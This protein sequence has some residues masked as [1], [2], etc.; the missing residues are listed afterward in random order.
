M[1]DVKIFKTNQLF[2]NYLK[3]LRF[4]N[5]VFKGLS[6]ESDNGECGFEG[7]W[8]S[9]G[10]VDNLLGPP[11]PKRGGG[12][13]YNGFSHRRGLPPIFT[14]LYMLWLEPKTCGDI[15]WGGLLGKYSPVSNSVF[16]IY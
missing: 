10:I 15:K 13:I 11:Y 2:Q 9:R 5:S 8:E 7:F 3:I 1:N 4:I 16:I 6:I 12:K 14:T